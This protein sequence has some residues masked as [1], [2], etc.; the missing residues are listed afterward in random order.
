MPTGFEGEAKLRST[1]GEVRLRLEEYGKRYSRMMGRPLARRGGCL[2]GVEQ[3][4][5]RQQPVEWHVAMKAGKR[6]ALRAT[7]AGRLRERI[8]HLKAQVRGKSRT[9]LS[10]A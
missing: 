8:E 10:L 3:R 7:A 4:P 6:R 2:T 9:P 5:E 1:M